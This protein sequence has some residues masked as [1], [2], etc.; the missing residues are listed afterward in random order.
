MRGRARWRRSIG[1]A[2][3]RELAACGAEVF[4]CGRTKVKL[5][6]L[7]DEI[8]AAGGQAHAA[9]VD[10]EDEL[11]VENY[12]AGITRKT[13]HIDLVFNAM[14]PRVGDYGNGTPAV[15]LAVDKYMI[16]LQTLVRSQFISSRAAARHMLK[17]RSGVI[18]FVTGSPARGH[19][20]GATAIGT[21]FGAIE[22]LMENLA[23][24]LSPSGIRVV[25]LRTTT[26]LDSRTMQELMALMGQKTGRPKE[27]M[28][29]IMAGM[30]FLK[31]KASVADTAQGIAYLASDHARMMT[32]TVVNASAGAALD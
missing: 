31:A 8:V 26:N 1:S 28:A 16:P 4:V 7:V 21:A 6:V 10:V 30:N 19:V 13:G 15:D 27:E 20:P 2:V 18:I 25:C 14:G 11:A 29:D 12:I 22:T 9:I 24:E 17:Q 23:V 5:D 32:G 3:A